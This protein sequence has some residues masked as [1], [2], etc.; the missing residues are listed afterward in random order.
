MTMN[1]YGRARD[2]KMQEAVE[3][4]GDMLF[5]DKSITKMSDHGREK[6]RTDAE[7]ENLS[8]QTKN[9]TPAITGVIL[10]KN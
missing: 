1:V 4:V 10:K 9:I 3:S 2:E 5:C 8:T 6:N 7:R